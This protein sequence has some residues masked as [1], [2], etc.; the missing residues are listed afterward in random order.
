VVVEFGPPSRWTSA[1]NDTSSPAKG[2]EILEKVDRSGY[3]VKT[4]RK[5]SIQTVL[6]F[7]A[8]CRR[9]FAPLQRVP[10]PRILTRLLI[11]C[12]VRLMHSFVFSAW[13]RSGWKGLKSPKLGQIG[14]SKGWFGE[15]LMQYLVHPPPNTETPARIDAIENVN[16]HHHHSHLALR[17]DFQ[18]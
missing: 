13:K 11:L 10:S 2:T 9:F 12:Q 6:A 18:F 14:E 17:D 5:V 7:Q 1:T 16:T 8:C 4:Q 15:P 3:E